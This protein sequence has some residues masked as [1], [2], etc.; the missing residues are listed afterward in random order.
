MNAK[1]LQLIK[2]GEHQRQD[3]KYCISDSR[4]IA[5]SLVAFANTDGGSLLIGVKDNGHIVGVQSDEEYYMA[6]SA[7][8]IYSKPPV[9]FTTRQWHVEGKTVLQVIVEPS[10]VKPHFA[11]DENNKWLA[12]IRYRDEN[13]LASKVM[14]DVWRKQKQPEGVLVHL[15]EAQRFLLDY[16]NK[17]DFI[18]VSA[19]ARRACLP[20]RKAE[21][22][23]A[24]FIVIGIIQP[25]IGEN[26]IFYQ[27]N[28][29]FDLKAWEAKSKKNLF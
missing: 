21:Q 24:D 2:E 4:K 15:D 9:P 3:F 17:Y 6:E 10:N 25:Y 29:Q 8:R 5:R 18:T 12:Y 23:L 27:L 13:R 16:L 19:F 1:L 26:N 7:A 11:K 22:L 14:L 28:R 20:Y